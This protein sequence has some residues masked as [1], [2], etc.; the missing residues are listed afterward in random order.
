MNRGF[1]LGSA[2]AKR[3]RAL[4]LGLLLV[5]SEGFCAPD[6]IRVRNRRA[7]LSLP[8][9]HSVDVAFMEILLADVY[10]LERVQ[11]LDTILDV[12]AHVGLFTLAASIV[13]PAA[14]IHSYEPNID[15]AQH[16]VRNTAGTG[17][18]VYY[19]AV[20]ASDGRCDLETVGESVN[21]RVQRSATGK[22]LVTAFRT[23]VQR[24]GGRV[25]FVK[26]D[27]EGSEWELLDD[28]DA[29]ASVGHVSLEFHGDGARAVRRLEELGFAVAQAE[30]GTY[31]I[32]IADRA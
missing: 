22:V 3:R 32:V 6:R 28:D 25:D 29:W 5:R 27:C 17:A 14:R 18:V 12:G 9:E 1:Q 16:L 24:L 30:T 15:L 10:G 26:I 23:A 19:E 21:T 8:R 13:H 20:G 11:R 31:G 4:R 7:D 2:L